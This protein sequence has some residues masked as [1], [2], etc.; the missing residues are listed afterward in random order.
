MTRLSLRSRGV[1]LTAV[2]VCAI[3]LGPGACEAGEGEAL[4]PGPAEALVASAVYPGLGQLWNDSDHKAAIVGG[5]EAFLVM[6]LLLEDRRTRHALRLYTETEES[7][8]FE[9]YSR[10]FDTRQTLVWWVVVAALYGI[11]DAYVDA[12]LTGF[13]DMRPPSLDEWPDARGSGGG[14]FRIGLAC[15]F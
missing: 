12:H 15:R 8:Y 6:R 10:H 5:A 11:A 9:D 14:G 4:E 1:L 7:R 2:V 3:T 13:E